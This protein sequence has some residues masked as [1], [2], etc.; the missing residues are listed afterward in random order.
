[1]GLFSFIGTFLCFNCVFIFFLGAPTRELYLDNMP[2][3]CYIGGPALP[4]LIDGV[5]RMVVVDGPEP[6]VKIGEER[7]DLVL[8]KIHMI[9]NG[10][11]MV[12]VFLDSKIQNFDMPET[13]RHTLQLA[14]YLQTILIDGTP[15]QNVEYGGLPKSFKIGNKTRFI[16][17]TTLPKGVSQGKP[18]NI[19]KPNIPSNLENLPSTSVA[20]TPIVPLNSTQVPAVT[21]TQDVS[22]PNIQVSAVPVAATVAPGLNL[23]I[24]ELF[25][26]LI[27]SGIIGGDKKP[28][29]KTEEPVEQ[30][31]EEIHKID[32]K[33]PKTIKKRSAGIVDTL[34]N[35]MQ[36]SSC[37]VRFPPEQTI[38]YS[39]H[40]DWHFRQ[41]RRDRDASK[42]AHSRK[43]YYDVSDWIQFEEI[44]DLEE[45]EKNWFEKHGTQAE[46]DIEEMER[47]PKTQM[48]SCQAGPKGAEE[49]CE[50]CHDKFEY[51]FNEENEDWHLKNAIR[52]DEKCYHPMCYDDHKAV[53]ARDKLAEEKALE[54]DTI[55]PNESSTEENQID[56]SEPMEQDELEKTKEEEN[57]ETSQDKLD[58][59]E[60]DDVIVLPPQ[61]PTI[62][63]ILDDDDDELGY[64]I[65]EI[66]DTTVESPNIENSNKT[67]EKS[68]SPISVEEYNPSD[69]SEIRVKKEP[70]DDLVDNDDDA[71]EDVGTMEVSIL[72]EENTLDSPAVPLIDDEASNLSSHDINESST[73]ALPEHQSNP[74]NSYDRNLS[75]TQTYAP[76]PLVNKIIVNITKPIGAR[77]PKETETPVAS[78][79][80]IA[81]ADEYYEEA[82]EDPEPEY[83][84]KPQLKDVQFKKLPRAEVG[85][86]TSGLCSIM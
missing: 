24:E 27:T 10:S 39:Q 25:Q 80:H 57:E 54:M 55:N 61:N 56:K 40:L 28:E 50:V 76:T 65:N 19:I 15:I 75:M 63:E 14:N 59:T 4:I 66:E 51:F 45:R 29:E 22:Q 82:P 9:I 31:K 41:N 2:Y 47:S 44:E 86:E 3:E 42:K 12:P 11:I 53:L 5:V 46:F 21:S 79:S 36:C 69:M 74:N 67:K 34:Y 64:K 23:N 60:D 35:G 8:G 13:S 20:D 37:G 17:F 7:K 32:L 70:M 18:Q 81:Q 38:K 77:S 85:Y 6:K 30:K 33:Q 1:M 78:P 26:R 58:E 73:D 84:I 68:K 16:R 52:V 43:W 71:F 49:T 62:T 48:I 72:D 83:E